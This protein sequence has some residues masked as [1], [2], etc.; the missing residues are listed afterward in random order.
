MCLVLLGRKFNFIIK[1]HLLFFFKKPP[2]VINYINLFKW[3]QIPHY[4][5]MLKHRKKES[6]TTKNNNLHQVAPISV[7]LIRN[8]RITTVYC[9][10]LR[11]FKAWRKTKK[12]TT[13]KK[14]RSTIALIFILQTLQIWPFRNST[15]MIFR[16][17][18]N[19]GHL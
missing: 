17:T 16:W 1:M 2:K 6:P 18:F 10:Q 12:E 14:F 4:T 8:Q 5:P 19:C 15:G 13:S 7:L 3:W 11:L 9:Q